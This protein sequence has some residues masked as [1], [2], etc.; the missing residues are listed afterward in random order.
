MLLSVAY[1]SRPTRKLSDDELIELWSQ[2]REN[3]ERL[4]I[5]GALYY[6]SKIFFQVLEGEAEFLEALI[7]TIEKD[8]R[9]TDFEILVENDIASPTFRNWPLK[10]LDGRNSQRLQEMFDYSDLRKMP[11]AKV[12]ANVF[13]LSAI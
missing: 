5:T 11:P 6:D 8:P 7:R 10:F 12:N 4:R 13:T 9:H 1:C 2:G 3:N